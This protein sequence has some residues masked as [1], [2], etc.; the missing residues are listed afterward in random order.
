MPSSRPTPT[1]LCY[2]AAYLILV[3]GLAAAV[4]LVLTRPDPTP[5]R[6]LDFPDLYNSKRQT[7]SAE[8]MAGKGYVLLLKAED[9]M[10]L[11]FKGKN[12]GYTVGVLTVLI[13]ASLFTVGYVESLLLHDSPPAKRP[14]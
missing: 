7:E 8:Q 13:S 12:L 1:R 5:K 3:F 4:F 11:W 2:D 10:K 6:A 9:S 14:D